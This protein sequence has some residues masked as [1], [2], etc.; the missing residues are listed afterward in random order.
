MTYTQHNAHCVDRPKVWQVPNRE[1]PFDNPV[2]L[3]LISQFPISP[4]EVHYNYRATYLCAVSSR[5]Y[6]LQ[7]AKR[8]MELV[9]SQFSGMFWSFC[10]T[11]RHRRRGS[12]DMT[13][14]DFG[15]YYRR[16]Y[17]VSNKIQK[18]TIYTML[19][20]STPLPTLSRHVL[21]GRDRKLCPLLRASLSCCVTNWVYLQPKREL[22]TGN[23][24]HL[25]C[26]GTLYH[27]NIEQVIC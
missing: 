26:L 4:L 17:R 2:L 19:R 25:A 13:T 7:Y 10:I 3:M 15:S 18:F 21:A 11:P 9:T 20:A 23:S 22:K 27:P 12:L 14:I 16:P 24:R 6:F 5:S 1:L 8:K